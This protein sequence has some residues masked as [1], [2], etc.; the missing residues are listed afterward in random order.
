MLPLFI[1]TADDFIV[2][3]KENN[4]MKSRGVRRDNVGCGVERW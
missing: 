2:K 4:N 1:E 3:G